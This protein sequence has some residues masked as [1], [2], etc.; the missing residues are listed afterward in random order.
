[1]NKVSVVF[2]GVG[3]RDQGFARGLFVV[4]RATAGTELGGSC[5]TGRAFPTCVQ[6]LDCRLIALIV[7]SGQ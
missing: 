7:Q 2:V 5:V 6:V 3:G 4:T 1:M